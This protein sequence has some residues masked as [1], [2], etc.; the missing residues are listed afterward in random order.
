M[1]RYYLSDT[2]SELDASCWNTQD[3]KVIGA[4]I[5]FKNLVRNASYRPTNVV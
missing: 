1:T 2:V 3:K 4:A 5:L